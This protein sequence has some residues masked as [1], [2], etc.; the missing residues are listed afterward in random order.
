MF[1]KKVTLKLLLLLIISDM[2]E[3]AIQIF[4]KKSALANADFVVRDL[5]SG[6]F[7]LGAVFASP[8]LWM[9][10]ATVVMVFIIWSSVLAKIDLSVAV[11]VA[12]FSYI[13]V[14]LTSIIFLHE[15]VTIFRW[16]GILLILTGVILV[17]LS[18]KE[19]LAHNQ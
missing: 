2:L 17:S 15:K 7:F 1:K 12:S 18:S 9:G 6:I 14:P 8:F 19:R 4:F 3:T 11:P 5:S 10:L 13:L 16:A